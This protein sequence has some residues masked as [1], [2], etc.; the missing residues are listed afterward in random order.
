MISRFLH[1]F[2]LALLFQY[3]IFQQTEPLKMFPASF[4]VSLFPAFLSISPHTQE[5]QKHKSEKLGLGGELYP[6][7][8]KK[9]DKNMSSLNLTKF[10]VN[11]GVGEDS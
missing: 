2:P 9:K 5:T 11:Y 10:N 1:F 8:K 7:L 6:S 3:F 4:P